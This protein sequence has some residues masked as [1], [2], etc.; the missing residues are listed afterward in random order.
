MEYNSES[1][2]FKTPPAH[3]K[4]NFLKVD[5]IRVNIAKQFLSKERF[6]EVFDKAI[7][8]RRT[9]INA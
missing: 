8:E 3:L 9:I 4:L 7:N 2:K 5:A 6:K 1:M